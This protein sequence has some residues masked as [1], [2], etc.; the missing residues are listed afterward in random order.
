MVAYL[1]ASAHE[2]TFSDY[3]QTARESEKE[4]VMDPSCNWAADKLSKTKLKSFFPLQ[5]LKGTQPTKASTVWAMHL[6]EESSNEEVDAVSE[7]PDGIND[8]IEEFIVCLTRAVKE[9]Q[10]D[11]KHCYNCSSME[12]FIHEC[13]QV[14]ASRS[15]AHLNQK[16]GIAPEKGAW[17]PPVKTTKLKVPQEGTPKA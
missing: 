10:Q 5:K 16:E 3:L 9:T 17:A 7:D 12:H 11:E 1:K 4:E 2:K 6:E 8:M 14:K 13:L 15:A